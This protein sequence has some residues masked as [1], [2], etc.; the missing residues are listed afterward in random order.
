[1]IIMARLQLKTD[2]VHFYDS[3]TEVYML[4][5]DDET[6]HEILYIWGWVSKTENYGIIRHSFMRN[7]DYEQ[8]GAKIRWLPDGDV[9]S[10][11]P[12][13][14]GL[15]R[16][17]FYISY[18][19]RRNLSTRIRSYLYPFVREGL[20]TAF[21]DALATQGDRLLVE[22]DRVRQS[23]SLIAASSVELDLM[24]DWY[25]AN[26]LPG[27]SDNSFRS[28][29][30]NFLS[31][32]LSSGTKNSIMNVI[33]AFTGVTPGI[34]E[35]WAQTAYW[36]YNPTDTSITYY[37]TSYDDPEPTEPIAYW[38]DFTFQLSTFYVTLP[39]ETINEYG[40]A[41]LKSLIDSSKASGVVGYLGYL[42]TETFADGNDDNWEPQ[43]SVQ[44]E[45][46]TGTW[47]V[48]VTDLD[49]IYEETGVSTTSGMSVVSDEY[50]LGCDDWEDY[51]VT[52]YCQN[53]SP[54]DSADT[55]VG[56]VVRWDENNDEFYFFGI[57]TF[58]DTYYIYKYQNSTW[59]LIV[60]D[61]QDADGNTLTFDKDKWYHFRVSIDG[62]GARFYVDN[63]LMYAH[64]TN[65][66][67]I[68]KGRP[69]F[70]AITANNTDIKGRFDDMTVVV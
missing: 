25:N 3:G 37:W 54:S 19:Y 50:H 46:S 6:D 43:T 45:T 67:E 28:R 42:V 59:T 7:V 36:N 16:T 40:I 26:R 47:S 56:I 24:G 35:L 48:D 41:A 64:S 12:S 27:E 13:F 30:E 4:D 8:V 18:I 34:Y 21:V 55:K 39:L 57:C 68:Q 14:M 33:R 58:N 10:P 52:A 51:V 29:L 15:T 38:W 23:R 17:P 66:N 20:A 31:V 9:P 69:G 1:M 2:E 49:Y 32:F 65:F 11:P 53:N 62:G 5:K 61:S 70:A 44:E 22:R 60:S 63:D